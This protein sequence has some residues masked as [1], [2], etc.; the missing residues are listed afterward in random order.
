MTVFEFVA[1]PNRAFGQ[2]EDGTSSCGFSLYSGQPVAKGVHQIVMRELVAAFYTSETRHRPRDRLR[3]SG[4]TGVI[5]RRSVSRMPNQVPEIAG[6]IGVSG[7][8][9]QTRH[10]SASGP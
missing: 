5:R 10:S 7:D 8:R 3:P 9:A 1:P 6:P 2:Q 4:S